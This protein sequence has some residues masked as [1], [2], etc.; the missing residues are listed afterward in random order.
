VKT[1]QGAPFCTYLAM[2]I[3]SCGGKKDIFMLPPRLKL[4]EGCGR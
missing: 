3:G 4:V 2:S 1:A